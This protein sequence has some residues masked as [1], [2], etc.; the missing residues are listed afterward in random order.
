MRCRTPHYVVSRRGSRPRSVMYSL[1]PIVPSDFDLIVHH[2]AEMFRDSGR[3]EKLLSAMAGPFRGWLRPRLDDGSYFGWVVEAAGALVAGLG[4]MVIGWP[5]HPSHPAQDERGY[6]L[7]VYVESEHRRQGLARRLMAKAT[8]EA[9]RRGL[10]HLVLHATAKG[11][12]LY[13]K[14]GWQATSEMSIT[15][16]PI[17]GI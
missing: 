12:T 15:L 9:L 2:R 14:L 16:S 3:S 8:D 7:N 5:P 4:M 13:E 11:R 17:E 1:R 10:M 6:I